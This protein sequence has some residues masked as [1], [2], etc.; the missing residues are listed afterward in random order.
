MDVFEDLDIKLRRIRRARHLR[1]SI[2]A[3]GRIL[4]TRPFW[5][6]EKVARSFLLEKK[7]WLEEQW[8]ELQSR[9]A[10]LFRRG[11]RAEYL[12]YKEAARSLAIKKLAHFNQYYNFSIKRLSIRDQRSRWGSCSKAGGINFN[13]RLVF[14]P[15]ELLDYLIVHE[16]CHLG[17]LNHSPSFWGL[18]AKTIPDYSI[19]R[20]ALHNL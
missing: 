3:D 12:E 9:P 11:G 8:R 10:K 19:R 2:G 14:L 1:L 17:E 13:Y 6:S 20:K 18:V 15:E 16:L 4:L 7:A 5:V